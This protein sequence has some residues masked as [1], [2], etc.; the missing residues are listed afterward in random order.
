[1]PNG[2]DKVPGDWQKIGKSKVVAIHHF[3]D[4]PLCGGLVGHHDPN[5][6]SHGPEI[7]CVKVIKQI[8]AKNRV[9]W[10]ASCVHL[11]K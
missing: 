4:L 5:C 11:F 9:T 2:K 3:H 6:A 10:G 7:S 8:D 1:M